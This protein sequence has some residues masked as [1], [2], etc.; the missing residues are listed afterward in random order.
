MSAGSAV[1]SGLLWFVARTSLLSAA[2]GITA[3]LVG[4][5][6]LAGVT[7]ALLFEVEPVDPLTFGGAAVLVALVAWLAVALPARRALRVMP[8]AALRA[9]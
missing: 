2:V 7:T 8:M 9:D 4:A 1:R 3:G 6:L 5:R